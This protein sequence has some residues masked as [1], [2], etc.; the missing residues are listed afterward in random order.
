[1]KI[2]QSTILWSLPIIAAGSYIAYLFVEYF[3]E[4]S[5]INPNETP[6]SS[7][8]TPTVSNPKV[9]DNGSSFPLKKGVTNDYV[10]QLQGVLGV[11]PQ[12]GYF[13]SLTSSALLEQTGKTQIDSL[14]D[15]N[16]AIATIFANDSPLS[17]QKTNK[18]NAI[19]DTYNQLY[20]TYNQYTP[21][22]KG[23]IPNKIYF[24]ADTT[25]Y[26]ID[27]GGQQ[28]VMYFSK[29]KTLSLN[30][31]AP[32]SVDLQGNLTLIC[33]NGDNAGSWTVDPTNLTIQ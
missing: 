28:Y 5:A 17:I 4:K 18:S 14:D 29:G 9:T 2:K 32:T 8:K 6:I 21:T 16:A 27:N 23:M 15:L 31:Y 12:S 13:G 11:T 22:G 19:I 25:L 7:P 10:K 1:M 24:G 3:K 26:S 20:S 33:N 30:D